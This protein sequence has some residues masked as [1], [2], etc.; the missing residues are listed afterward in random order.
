MEEA[1]SN[2]KKIMHQKKT[3]TDM[4]SDLNYEN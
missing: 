1:F 2:K 3:L 4:D